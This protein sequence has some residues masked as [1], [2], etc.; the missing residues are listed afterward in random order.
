M[1][2]KQISSTLLA[3]SSGGSMKRSHSGSELGSHWQ[4]PCLACF[5]MSTSKAYQDLVEK[6]RKLA[7]AT[8]KVKAPDAKPRPMS[9]SGPGR[10]VRPPQERLNPVGPVSPEDGDTQERLHEIMSEHV[11]VSLSPAARD[12][13]RSFSSSALLYAVLSIVSSIVTSR[14]SRHASAQMKYPRV[15]RS[16][17]G[18]HV[19]FCSVRDVLG[20]VGTGDVWRVCCVGTL[21]C[22]FCVAIVTS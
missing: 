17:S 2:G 4:S 20:A 6:T 7:I 8:S 15:R 3:A 16:Q 10:F 5:G 21:Q 11:R 14:L 18:S 1:R 19:L 22:T 12:Q 9:S 13:R